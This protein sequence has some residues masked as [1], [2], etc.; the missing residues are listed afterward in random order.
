MLKELR[1]ADFKLQCF[2]VIGVL[3]SLAV[4]GSVDLLLD[5]WRHISYLH[6]AI[7]LL[8][9]LLPLAGAGYMLKN[10]AV[11][12]RQARSCEFRLEDYL[13]GLGR[14]IEADFTAWGLTATE[15]ETAMLLLKGL[16]HKKIAIR[17]HRSEGTVRQQAGTVYRKA[18][19][20]SRADL[21][22]YFVQALFFPEE[23]APPEADE[24]TPEKAALHDD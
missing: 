7:E 16:S 8:I 10:I 23:V 13:A 5:D 17:R 1:W 19:V 14:Q 20:A 15:R 6:L 21:A 11:A 24:T 22:A 3:L 12:R 18:G 9:I 4:L 2:K